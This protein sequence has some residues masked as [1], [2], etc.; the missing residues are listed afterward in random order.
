MKAIVIDHE[1]PAHFAFGE[2]EEPRPAANE[3]VVGVAATSL[4][5]GELRYAQSKDDGSATGWDLAGYV[6]RAAE[7]GSGPPVGARVVGF[8]P[9]GAWAERVAVPTHA[10]AELP[11]EVSFPCAAALPV[12]GLTALKVV[13]LASGLL[14]RRALVTGANGGVGMFA[15]QIARLAGARVTAQ[16]RRA[17]FEQMVAEVADDIA[18][19]EDGS[20]AA[21]FGPYR[22]I[23]ESVGGAVL[24]NAVNMLDH[25]GICVTYGGSASPETLVNVRHLMRPGRA[26][27]YG[28][29]LFNELSV[30]PAGEGLARLVSLVADGRLRTHITVEEPWE[31]APQVAT[32][33]WERRIAGKAVLHLR[34]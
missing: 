28:F 2:L 1:S 5:L 21:P 13:D 23:A 8:V 27:L 7:D 12:A 14:G 9:A 30:E 17:Q 26:V 20:A 11:D 16:I 22:L 4:N 18:V 34:R 29:L 19:G 15:C 25:D 32:D 10:L 6:E 31:R 24:T 3:A 33:L